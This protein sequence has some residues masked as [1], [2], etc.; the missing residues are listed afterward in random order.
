MYVGVGVDGFNVFVGNIVGRGIAVFVG[1][2]LASKEATP[3]VT[4]IKNA[5]HKHNINKPPSNNPNAEERIVLINHSL[6][7]G[8]IK[9]IIVNITP[10]MVTIASNPCQ[11]GSLKSIKPILVTRILR[12]VNQFLTGWVVR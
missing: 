1:V 10:V 7:S 5:A 8:A 9:N 4:G 11:M 6:A 3:F 2:G 12:N